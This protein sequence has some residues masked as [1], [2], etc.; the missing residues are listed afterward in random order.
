MPVS[1]FDLAWVKS[2]NI[3]VSRQTPM[4]MLIERNLNL[5]IGLGYTWEDDTNRVNIYFEVSQKGIDYK[6]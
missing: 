4:W 5:D 2:N 3:F 6:V 1:T